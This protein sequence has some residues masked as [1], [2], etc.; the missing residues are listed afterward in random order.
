MFNRVKSMFKGAIIGAASLGLL[1]GSAALRAALVDPGDEN[2]AKVAVFGT[3]FSAG[4]GA[5]IGG[6]F[7][8][9]NSCVDDDSAD[10]VKQEETF[11]VVKDDPESFRI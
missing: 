3:F 1:G 6:V 8:A 9:F 10:K 5:V 11:L 4:V 2:D 7:G